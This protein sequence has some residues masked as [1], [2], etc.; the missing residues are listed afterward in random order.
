MRKP[1]KRGGAGTIRVMGT[2]ST[3]VRRIEQLESAVIGFGRGVVRHNS[4]AR[5]AHHRAIDVAVD[6][7]VRSPFATRDDVARIRLTQDVDFHLRHIDRLLE[8][9]F[10]VYGA[11]ADVV[12]ALEA[13]ELVLDALEARDRV[14]LGRADRLIECIL[15]ATEA[16]LVREGVVS[17]PDARM[18]RIALHVLAI[19]GAARP[20]A[21]T[22]RPSPA[23]VA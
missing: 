19:A 9:P 8:A 1:L 5:A 3:Y 12:D 21:P 4:C 7:L 6:A 14:G 2:R 22:G 13:L 10:A 20:P 18:R 17:A 23:P 11:S 15:E 16:P